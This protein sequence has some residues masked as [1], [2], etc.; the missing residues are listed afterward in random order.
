MLYV[1]IIICIYI[2]IYQNN[3]I[4]PSPFHP[5]QWT[6]PPPVPESSTKIL[7]LEELI[8]LGHRCG[9]TFIVITWWPRSM[10]FTTEG[11]WSPWCQKKRDSQKK[12]KTCHGKIDGFRLRFS[13]G[14]VK[15]LKKNILPKETYGFNSQMY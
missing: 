8:P 4:P 15:S 10:G 13:H 6:I 1:Y 11:Q 2:L 3:P 5:L 7:P 12:S 14:K 9:D